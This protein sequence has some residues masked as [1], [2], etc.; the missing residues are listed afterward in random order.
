MTTNK[1]V[2]LSPQIM[3]LTKPCIIESFLAFT[4]N[5]KLWD[6]TIQILNGKKRILYLK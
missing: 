3:P 4:W 1:K 2:L 5:L 6:P